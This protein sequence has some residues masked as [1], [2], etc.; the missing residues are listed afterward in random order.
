[1]ADKYLDCTELRCPM[2]IVKISKEVK[3][4][5]SGQ[6]LAVKASDPAFASDI[7]A[8]VTTMGY[9]L[10]ELEEGSVQTAVIRKP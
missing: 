1:M 3:Q 9:E 2:P 4:M 10:L 8:W 7:Q 5:S 6:T